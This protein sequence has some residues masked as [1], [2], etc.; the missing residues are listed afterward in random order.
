MLDITSNVTFL[1]FSDLVKAKEFITGALGLK[2]AYD[3]GWACVYRLGDKSFLGAVDASQGS[4]QVSSRDGVL[5]SLTVSDI[6]AAYDQIRS[7]GV[8]GLSEIKQV[9]DLALQSFFFTGP[10]GYQFEVQHFTSG[11][12]KA[13]F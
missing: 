2:V 7:Y 3:P 12:L 11:E 1:Y 5:V 8:E 10:E 9:K 6:D 4:I 13:L